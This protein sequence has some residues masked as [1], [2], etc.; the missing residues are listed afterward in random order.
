[1]DN[2]RAH[3][4]SIALPVNEG[5]G[6]LIQYSFFASSGDRVIADRH[7]GATPRERLLKAATTS[8]SSPIHSIRLPYSNFIP[9]KGKSSGMSRR[10]VRPAAVPVGDRQAH[11][12]T[13]GRYSLFHR[14]RLRG[15]ASC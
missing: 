14:T 7:G 8:I 9:P 2:S 15:A 13:P 6:G 3:F 4:V 11:T 1:M 12:G 5:H 10:S